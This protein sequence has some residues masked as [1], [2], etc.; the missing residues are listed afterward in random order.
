MATLKGL[1]CKSFKQGSSFFTPEKPF[2]SP[3]SPSRSR[4]QEANLGTWGFKGNRAR[5][6]YGL[7]SRYEG[8][9]PGFGDQLVLGFGAE[10]GFESGAGIWGLN[11]GTR[12][13]VVV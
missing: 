8:S 9:R 6:L 10:A 3:T 7:Q 2:P 11:S 4:V 5:G 1:F 12:V 13:K